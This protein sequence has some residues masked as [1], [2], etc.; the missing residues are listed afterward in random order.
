VPWSL[1]LAI[2]FALVCLL[3]SLLIAAFATWVIRRIAWKIG[4]LDQ[5]SERKVHVIPVPL[6]GGIGIWF[7]LV[8]PFFVAHVMLMI[9]GSWPDLSLGLGPLERFWDLA[10]TH[11]SGYQEQSGSLWTLLMLA[12][13]LAAVGLID[14]MVG[15]SWKIRLGVQFAV[16]AVVVYVLEWKLS[17][18]LETPL[19][20]EIV[21]IFW[22][23][24]M[25]NSFN[26]LDNM[27]A[28]SGGIAAI[29]SV[30]LSIVVLLAPDPTTTGPQLFIGGFLLVLTGSIAGF[31]VHNRPPAK[32]FMGD[33]G[34][35]LIGFCVAVMTILAT[36]GTYEGNRQ[37]AIL[38]PLCVL[39]IPL[40]DLITVLY[41][42][43][44]E[45]RSPFHP[46]KSHFSHRLVEMGF[47]K[48]SAVGLIYLL[49]ATC[50]LGAILLHRVD[51]IGA[52]VV[53][54]LVFCVLSVI[55]LIESAARRKA[56]EQAK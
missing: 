7:G 20:P 47:T 23:V 40:Y 42:R 46:D 28:L 2:T 11:A 27:D 4:L 24:A 33:A 8:A 15:L 51:S 5:P 31:L 49:T 21:S 56:R 45:G 30:V 35:Y 34:S 53:I 55:A 32:I 41:I 52:L 16:A 19:V 54:L 14:D 37:H 3:P 25:I 39:A 18:F 44:R 29:A 10:A 1:P 9:L 43:L 50:G 26:M 38:A 36:F 12:T 6:G 13:L 22:I 48:K 17:F